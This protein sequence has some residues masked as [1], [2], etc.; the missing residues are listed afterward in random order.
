M[1]KRVFYILKKILGYNPYIKK[2]ALIGYFC[3]LRVNI[4][5]QKKLSVNKYDVKLFEIFE[6]FIK[7]TGLLSGKINVSSID[8]KTLN[9]N[10][11]DIKIEK[12]ILGYYKNNK[13]K[14]HVSNY[15]NSK[16]KIA[17]LFTELYSTGGHTPLV[18]R[19]AESFLGEYDLKI[20][21]TRLD[22][23]VNGDYKDKKNNL[24]SKIDIDG[25]NWNFT[26]DKMTELIASL[27]NK[28]VDSKTDVIFCYIH[29]HDVIIAATI[30]LLKKY[31]NIKIII[32]NIQDHFYSLGF[33]FAH[34]IIDARPAGQSITKNIRGYNNTILM[35]LQQK[36]KDQTIYFTQDE[37]NNLR[38]K[39][40]INDEEF[41]TL[42]GCA[43][44]KI[45][46]DNDSP[47]LEMVRDLL[48][49]EPRL[50]HIIMTKF[51]IPN[52]KK[53]FSAVFK[54]HKD[55]LSRLKIIERVPEF[56]LYMQAC[57]LFID[58]FPQGGALIHIDMMRNKRPT[59]LKINAANP[60]RS[61]EYYLPQSYKYMY[62][63]VED[64]K[65]G[66]LKL[67]HSKTEADKVSNQLYQ[68]YLNNYE[69]YTVKEKYKTL[70]DNSDNLEKFYGN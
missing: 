35:P 13:N 44:Y 24:C 63:N 9:T 68:H 14:F 8:E 57:D 23:T 62:A 11:Y 43:D 36:A 51:S 55:L 12:V 47:Y 25:V 40:S 7:Y 69:F 41:F 26:L 3:V 56:D 52:N 4:F 16:R 21:A 34:L 60:I 70:I 64:M 18:E 38:K 48:I 27:Y 53:I 32:I 42:T 67:L 22:F 19:L 45:F 66:I 39:L 2:L 54:G 17:I 5:I 65:E 6:D 33:R 59:V 15:N 29:P 1:G 31:T 46:G 61:F 37:K 20:F 49:Q 30:G 28:I 58:S 50:K 10:S